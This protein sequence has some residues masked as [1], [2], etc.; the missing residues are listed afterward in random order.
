MV[1]LITKLVYTMPILASTL[2]ILVSSM[3]I[4]VL[5][6]QNISNHDNIGSM[7]IN[8]DVNMSI[9]AYSEPMLVHTKPDSA[10]PIAI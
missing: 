3:S 4:F 6:V 1:Q 9:F 5:Y 2:P 10:M 8:I 7:Y